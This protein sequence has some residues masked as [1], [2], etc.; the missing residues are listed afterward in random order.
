MAF[1]EML[2]F[3]HNLSPAMCLCRT[4]RQRRVDNHQRSGDK[5][6]KHKKAQPRRCAQITSNS[7]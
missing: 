6:G 4:N 2:V 1:F 5:P 7:D 3:C